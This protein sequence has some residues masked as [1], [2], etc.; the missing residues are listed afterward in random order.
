MKQQTSTND[1]AKIVPLF[2]FRKFLY[3]FHLFKE[4][5]VV[6]LNC[7]YLIV[8]FFRGT[9]TL[10]LPICHEERKKYVLTSN[11]R[12]LHVQAKMSATTWRK[13]T[14][15]HTFAGRR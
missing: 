10:E 15:G 11:G 12:S 8:F 7:D 9:P 13:Q 2:R 6:T 1:S 3:G 4:A 14:P 5:F